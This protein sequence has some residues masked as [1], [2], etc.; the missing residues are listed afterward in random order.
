MTLK[1]LAFSAHQR[2]EA[3][4]A[5]RL[6]R[7]H[8]YELLAAA[9]HYKTY[10]ALTCSAVL[11]PEDPHSDSA[12]CHHQEVQKRCL[13]LGYTDSMSHVVSGSVCTF[14]IEQGICALDL[15]VLIKRLMQHC[16][17]D[18]PAEITS[19]NVEPLL[20][21]QLETSAEAGSARSHFALALIHDSNEYEGIDRGHH[22]PSVGQGYW[23]EQRQL[24]RVL[25]EPELA[26]AL[27]YEHQ[28]ALDE[29]TAYEARHPSEARLKFM[30]H[31]R[32]AARLGL[33][34]AIEHLASRLGECPFVPEAVDEISPEAAFDLALI[35]TENDMPGEATRWMTVA[36]E[37][38]HVGA[39]GNLVHGH[40][41][42]NPRR[43]WVWVY[44]AMLLGVDLR[45]SRYIAINEDGSEYDDDVGGPAYPYCTY[46][47]VEL[48]ALS[49]NER[50]EAQH[51][52]QSLF[53]K[54]QS[55]K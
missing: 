20:I 54:V 30:H 52:A 47:G 25:T 7:S 1:N 22:A 51:S 19:V 23:Y 53:D 29:R 49:P 50:A 21:S 38:G 24:G 33:V 4:A 27:E 37:K 12:R 31:L 45:E 41:Y 42:N 15:S 26:F 2:A 18:D 36:A 55:R 5:V 34:D 10:K 48:A 13:E 6:S 28:L 44:L 17:D 35:A 14:L 43:C 11:I 40:D 9:F 3:A 32:A 16:D 39:M 8:I 46:E